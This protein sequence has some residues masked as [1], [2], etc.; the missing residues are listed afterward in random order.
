MITTKEIAQALDGREYGASISDVAKMAKAAGIVICHG[1][2]DDLVEFDGAFRDE[3]G[4]PGVVFLSPDGLL[5]CKCDDDR[6]PHEIAAQ[7]AAPRIVAFWCRHGNDGPAWTFE[8]LIPH[9]KF[10]LMEDGE[11]FSEGIVFRMADI[12]LGKVPA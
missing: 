1:A 12:P 3:V 8:T 4:G 9:E 5:E 6:C 7:K 2:S 10:K 11:V